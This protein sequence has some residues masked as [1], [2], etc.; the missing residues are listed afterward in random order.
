M[1]ETPLTSEV[2]LRQAMERLLAGTPERTDGRLIKENLYR[3]AG[4][5][6]ATMNRYSDVLAEWDSRVDSPAPRDREI[7]ALEAALSDHRNTIRQ[8]R[9]NASELEAQL[10][11]AATVIAELTLENEALRDRVASSTVLPLRRPSCTD[12]GR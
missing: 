12:S 2:K 11:K 3:E 1:A 9:A 5:S 10:T 4:V 8:L 7:Q 6:R